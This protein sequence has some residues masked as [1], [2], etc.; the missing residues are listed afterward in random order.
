[1]RLT[2]RTL[3][4]GSSV[5]ILLLIVISVGLIFSQRSSQPTPGPGTTKPST[6]RPENPFTPTPTRNAD[7]L[8]LV[9]KQPTDTP[10]PTPTLTPTPTITPTATPLT[11]SF[12]DQSPG[13]I[14]I[15]DYATITDTL[16]VEFPGL[17]LDLDVQINIS[18]RYAGDLEVSL[19][20]PDGAQAVLINRPGA[21]PNFCGQ[22][23]IS[24]TFDDEA[25][26]IGNQLC[27]AQPPAVAGRVRPLFPLF[28]FENL[29]ISGNWQLQVAD[30]SSPDEGALNQ[31]CLIATMR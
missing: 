22:D 9:G 18:H 4:L 24:A 25:G 8:P 15:Q 16:P 31:W 13:A 12:C 2:Q 5:L 28:V 17:I 27:A 29:P 11:L 19:V 21:P 30:K 1:M 23:D 26:V 6:P 20:A 7:F 14:P 10:T 3:L